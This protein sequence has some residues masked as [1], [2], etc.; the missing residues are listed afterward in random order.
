[1]L[2]KKSIKK[3]PVIGGYLVSPL[4]SADMRMALYPPNIR[5]VVK[6][7]RIKERKL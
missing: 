2:K 1:M 7:E 6:Y 3:P 5:K 4:L